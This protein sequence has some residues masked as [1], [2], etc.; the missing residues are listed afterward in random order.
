M[1]DYLRRKQ[2]NTPVV[3][4]TQ[5]RSSDVSSLIWRHKL[6]V[7]TVSGQGK[8]VM[9]NGFDPSSTQMSVPNKRV[10]TF[11]STGFGG[12]NQDVSSYVMTVSAKSIAKDVFT[13]GKIQTNTF[14]AGTT[15]CL[16]RTPASQVV[17]ELGN[18]E[19]HVSDSTGLNMAYMRQ[20]NVNG[21][22]V[23]NIG[24]CNSRFTPE[25][26][27]QFVDYL[28]NIK[29]G[30]GVQSRDTWSGAKGTAYGSQNPLDPKCT[31]VFT[32]GNAKISNNADGLVPKA[33]V[34]LGNVSRPYN[35]AFAVLQT[36][37]TG[38]QVGTSN[39]RGS[40]APKV[41]SAL[42]KIPIV[43]SNKG[44]EP[45]TAPLFTP[46]RLNNGMRSVPNINVPRGTK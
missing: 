45:R 8:H 29:R 10:Q 46:Y 18:A 33:L 17:S 22:V 41:G 1:S 30:L 26:Q 5:M 40:R 11:N 24:V 19:S 32:S 35:Q 6:A 4:D 21:S 31:T 23:D 28:P 34:P 12:R 9:T 42:R 36:A 13:Q 37:Q 39:V 44:P 3:K 7:S 16:T 27:S 2:I 20:R 15:E 43:S 25:T 38:P 14:L